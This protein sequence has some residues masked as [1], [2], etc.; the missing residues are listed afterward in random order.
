MAESQDFYESTLA[1]IGELK[2]A[3]PESGAMFGY[4]E[5]VLQAQKETKT[6]FQFDLDALDLDLCRAR[7]SEGACLLR[8]EGIKVDW[9]LFD[10]LFDRVSQISRERAGRSENAETWPTASECRGDWHDGLLKG[11]LT[12]R[13]LVVPACEAGVSPEIFTFLACQALTPFIEAHAERL[14]GETDDSAW[15]RGH[16]P[17]CGGEP[18]MG[19]LN[20]DTGKR[21]LQCHLCRTEWAFKR[22]ECPFC[23]NDDQDKLRFFCD[24][25][26]RAHRVDVCDAC[27]AYLKTV[28]ARETE[29]EP[30]LFVENLLTTHL[31][32]VAMREG[33]HR[34]T[35]KL[36]GL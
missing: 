27:K 21:Y 7:I 15:S 26:D 13:D 32:L 11:L 34:E 19:R 17:I 8:P 14:R 33:F 36:F 25:D 9:G 2:A 29:R 5:A 35:N 23:G 12:D 10:R 30:S 20:K 22:L 6:A 24:E 4:Y 1:Q 18:L 28:D 16:C 31:D 3:M